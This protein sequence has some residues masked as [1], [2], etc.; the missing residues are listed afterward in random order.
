SPE[1]FSHHVRDTGQ[2]VTRTTRSREVVP[3][4]PTMETA[5]FQRMT[6]RPLL[7]HTIEHGISIAVQANLLHFLDMTARFPFAPECLPGTA[8]VVCLPGLQGGFER[9]L[10][11]MGKHEQL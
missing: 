6:R 8:P 2:N 1:S 4:D 3:L 7:A 9:A 11:R 10:I 5:S